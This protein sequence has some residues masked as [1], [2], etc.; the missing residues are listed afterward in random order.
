MVLSVGGSRIARVESPGETGSVSILLPVLNEENR[1]GPCLERLI[2]QGGDVAEI[3]VID[4]GS[5]DGTSAIIDSFAARDS[6]VKRLEA[7]HVPAGLN[8]KAWQ[9]DAGLRQSAAKSTW[10]LTIDADVRPKTELVPSLL[11]HAKARDVRVLSVATGQRVSGTLQAMVHP[12]LL[13]TLVYRYGIP[14]NETSHPDDVQAN[15]Q[16]ML[17]NR[18]TLLA[19][20]GFKAVA[21]SVCEDVTLARK[22]AAG[23]H[24]VGF[25]EADDLVQTEMYTAASEALLNWSRSL[26]MRD[27]YSPTESLLRIGEVILV[28]GL[29]LVRII[30]R[31]GP[32]GRAPAAR[33]DRAL[34]GLRLGVLAGTARA[35]PNRPASYWLSPLMDLP[36]AVAILARSVQKTHTWRGRAVAVGGTVSETN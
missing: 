2:A 36:A 17:I 27:R 8:S 14:G 18:Q 22:L 10:I 12:A 23:G 32:H 35:Y 11:A 7:D 4:G 6:R 29:P 34:L 20:G 24:S 30:G 28:Q 5:R 33:L 16:C 9:L 19:A 15:G 13:T 25:Y 1:L 31:G 21:D 3:L 26:H